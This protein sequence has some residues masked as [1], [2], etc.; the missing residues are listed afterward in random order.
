ML[1]RLDAGDMPGYQRPRDLRA[2]ACAGPRDLELN[3][4]AIRGAGKPVVFVA[5]RGARDQVPPNCAEEQTEQGAGGRHVIPSAA[6]GT[7]TPDE[8][9]P[10]PGSGAGTKPPSP[11]FTAGHAGEAAGGAPSRPPTPPRA[12]SCTWQAPGPHSRLR[13]RGARGPGPPGGGPPPAHAIKSLFPLP[14]PIESS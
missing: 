4:G 2:E 8:G 10:P 14:L 1:M 7:G 3:L 5:G 12:E 11:A 9:L 6:W 13:S